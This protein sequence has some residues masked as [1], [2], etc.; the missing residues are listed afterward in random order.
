[1]RGVTD[2]EALHRTIPN[3]VIPAKF[4]QRE[5]WVD[6]AGNTPSQYRQH[7]DTGEMIPRE[8]GFTKRLQSVQIDAERHIPGEIPG[9]RFSDVITLIGLKGERLFPTK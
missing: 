6:A 1:M 4:E 5:V 3:R 7:P 8:G 2:G 9:G